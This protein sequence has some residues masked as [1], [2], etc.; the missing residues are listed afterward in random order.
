[1]PALGR[2]SFEGHGG[3]GG[4]TKVP[5]STARTDV[6]GD[7]QRECSASSGCVGESLTKAEQDVDWGRA[8]SGR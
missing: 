1:M 3:G 7:L 8:S 2:W 4:T 5:H 6:K